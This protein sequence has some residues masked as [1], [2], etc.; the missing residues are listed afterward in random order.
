MPGLFANPSFAQLARV[1]VAKFQ[2]A[3]TSSATAS[4]PAVLATDGIVGN[5]NRWKSSSAGP[6]T[7]I[8]TLPLTMELGSAHLY[9]GRD[10]IEP[11]ASFVLQSWNGT[12]WVN[13]P[14]TAVTGNTNN[15]LN[16][17]FA[18]P[19]TTSRVRFS[20]T[21]PEVRLR[22][23]ALFPPNGPAGYPLGTD[24]TLN[25]AKKRLA[26]GSSVDGSSHGRGAVDGYVENDLG[27]WKS[28]SGT[29]P[30][31]L[32][33]DL[34]ESSRLGSAHLFLGSQG[35]PTVTNFTLQYWT[36]SAWA[37]IPGGGVTGNTNR[38]VRVEFTPP[39]VSSSRVRLHI[40]DSGSQRVREL[41]VFAA[42]NSGGYPLGT[43]V[44]FAAPPATKFDTY[45]D[46]FWKI[47]N[48]A[49]PN[50]L[51]VGPNGASQ[52]QP[53]STEEEK[54]FQLLYDLGSD[55]FRLRNRDSY[56]CIAAQ[57]AG[58]TNG[59]PV[60]EVPDYQGMPHE[61]WRFTPAGTQG[62]FRVVNVWSGLVLETDGGSPAKVTLAPAATGNTR[63]YWRF[64]FQT[65]YPKKGAG[66]YEGDWAKFG[67][68]WH[69][70]WGRDTGTSLPAQVAFSPMQHNRWWPD[71]NT[72]PEY[73]SGWHTTSKPVTLLGYN[74]P[75]QASQG[76]ISMT[77]AIA[78]W[79][80]LEQADV[81]LVSPVPVNPFNGWLA[82]F[83]SQASE[84]GY[85][86]D[87]TAVH[88]YGNPD[89]SGLI[90]TLQ[91]VYNT[92][93]R[94]VWLTEFSPVDWGGS[95]TWTEEDNYRFLSEFLWRVEDL[96]W[97]KRYAVFCFNDAPPSNPWDRVGPTGSMF[98]GDGST[99]TAYGQLYAGWDGDRVRR[100][101]TAY[102]LQGLGSMHRLRASS[103]TNAPST[104]DIRRGDVSAQWALVPAPT[105]NRS[106]II[107]LRD[108]RRL[109]FNGTTLEL[110]PPGT[111]GSQAEWGFNG[112]D[113]NGY[114]FIDH[115]TTS[116]SLRLARVNDGNGAP[117]ALN[118]SMEPFGTVQDATRWRFV[119][120]FQP[121]ETAAP[122][123]L[124]G[125]NAVGGSNRVTLTWSGSAAPDL[126]H[127]SIY[128]STTAGGPYARIATGLTTPSYVDTAVVQGVVYRYVVTA[129]DWIDNESAYSPE[130]NATPIPPLLAIASVPGSN[131]APDN[132][133]VTWFESGPPRL[134]LYSAT[135]LNQ[136]VSWTLTTN[137]VTFTDGLW[138]VNLP[139]F[140]NG[141]QFLRLQSE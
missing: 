89:A 64:D 133:Q 86:I 120:P 92:W 28:G 90:G 80:L 16:L 35:N 32:E 72:L 113:A 14:G 100:D 12:S 102:F 78:L 88:W 38:E 11:V 8:V 127:Y 134:R 106:Y 31:T 118:F 139:V 47:V 25:L 111:T 9:L 61:L 66:G 39:F 51:I 33:V 70:N 2:P 137:P 56:L 126:L 81:P 79:P 36:G 130:A 5:G 69:Y 74:E 115:H 30:H 85:R 46:G 96:P 124:A 138:T 49:Y 20:S 104:G 52:T 121:V 109:R 75:E 15:L 4:D 132:L 84:R 22:E 18:S 42:N 99:F 76:N 136:P 140:T 116:R 131:G 24:V 128:R 7:L 125:I 10:D 97:L 13:I 82:D 141:N 37:A 1:N 112:P 93:G 68:S 34:Q 55:A 83:Y 40:P 129:T 73:Y 135:N 65:H 60:V 87:Y 108:G 23:I 119:K 59:T 45:G 41:L 103:T 98:N 27:R 105:A 71:W 77:D 117:T 63:Q 110:A 94:P 48:R 43:D 6:H 57:G 3:Q 44:A 58:R 62:D 21:E 101:R 17:I 122:A 29:G 53:T 107:S 123:T 50:S 54:Y 67:T 26:L 91:S 19:V 95:A 114:T